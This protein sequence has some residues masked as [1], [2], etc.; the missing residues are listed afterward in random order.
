M[1]RGQCSA[2]P[3]ELVCGLTQARQVSIK[4]GVVAE[5]VLPNFRGLGLIARQTLDTDE[6]REIGPV[7]ARALAKPFDLL[8]S[9]LEQAWSKAESG[10]CISYLR[11][12][13]AGSVIVLEP[14][15]CKVDTKLLAICTKVISNDKHA[16]AAAQAEIRQFLTGI[17]ENK[18][19]D[20]IWDTM[21][22]TLANCQFAEPD[23]RIAA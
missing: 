21:P 13:N 16:S 23:Q 8:V 12:K 9:D 18:M 20:L 17:L 15:A 11:R 10:N 5:V 22:P 19:L 14:E 3:V 1:P 4:V 7:A 2:A 6:L